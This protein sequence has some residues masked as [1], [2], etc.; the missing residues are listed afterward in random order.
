[1]EVQDNYD[2]FTLNESLFKYIDCE[3]CGKEI[4]ENEDAYEIGCKVVC[5]ECFEEHLEKYREER[6]HEKEE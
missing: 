4:Y 6:Y 5:S 2:R 1:M 3:K